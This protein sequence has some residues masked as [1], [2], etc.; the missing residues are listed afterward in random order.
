[1]STPHYQEPKPFALQ[2]LIGGAFTVSFLALNLVGI[3]L[4]VLKETPEFWI[5]AGGYPV[6]LR[7]WVLESYYPGLIAVVSAQTVATIACIHAFIKR[8]SGTALL[9]LLGLTLCWFVT[10]VTLGVLV[11][12]NLWNLLNNQ[13]LHW[14]PA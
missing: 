10:V 11:A 9:C 13:P 14:D 12:N 7:E 5:N 2:M 4:T 3:A 6:W 1:M 8:H